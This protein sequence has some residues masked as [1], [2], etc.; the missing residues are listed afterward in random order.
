M[1]KKGFLLV[2][3]LV[4]FMAGCS[5][6]PFNTKAKLDYDLEGATTEYSNL[7]ADNTNEFI[8]SI[9]IKD[10]NAVGANLVEATVSINGENKTVKIIENKVSGNTITQV[11]INP[12]LDTNGNLIKAFTALED[13]NTI[14][15]VKMKFKDINENEI[16]LGEMYKSIKV[17]KSSSGT[18]SGGEVDN[19]PV[20][21]TNLSY[22]VSADGSKITL[23]WIDNGNSLENDILGYKVYREETSNGVYEEGKETALLAS[24]VAIVT[25]YSTQYIDSSVTAGKAYIY[26]VTAVDRAS[27]ESTYKSKPLYVAIYKPGNYKVTSLVGASVE[28]T[29]N[30]KLTWTK[31]VNSTESNTAT[32]KGYKI[33]RKDNSSGYILIKDINNADTAEFIDYD[34]N[35]VE[36]KEYTYKVVVYDEIGKEGE[37][38]ETTSIRVKDI[39]A[40]T[41]PSGIVLTLKPAYKL[42]IA[43]SKNNDLDLKDY[44]IEYT[45]NINSTTWSSIT[46]SGIT[47]TEISLNSSETEKT[48]YVRMKATDTSDNKSDYSNTE[49][50]IIDYSSYIPAPSNIV[51]SGGP[52]NVTLTW[53]K[54]TAV[55]GYDVI[56]YKIK[57]GTTPT[58]LTEIIET[59]SNNT[60]ITSATTPGGIKT[61][62]IWYFSIAAVEKGD[63]ENKVEGAYSRIEDVVVYDD[64]PFLRDVSTDLSPKGV[65]VKW[66]DV[67]DSETTGYVIY[68]AVTTGGTPTE[69]DFSYLEAKSKSDF[70]VQPDFNGGSYSWKVYQDESANEIGKT[71]WYKVALYNGVYDSTNPKTGKFSQSVAVEDKGAPKAIEYSTLNVSAMEPQHKMRIS[72]GG[73]VFDRED[74]AGFKVYISRT[75][76]GTYYYAGKTSNSY[77]DLNVNKDGDF[78]TIS[79][80]YPLEREDAKWKNIGITTGSGITSGAAIISNSEVSGIVTNVN[81]DDYLKIEEHYYKVTDKTAD[82]VSVKPNII[83]NISAE[84]EVYMYQGDT[85]PITETRTVSL[86]DPMGN[87]MFYIKVDAYNKAGRESSLTA[88]KWI[89][90]VPPAP[91]RLNVKVSQYTDDNSKQVAKIEWSNNIEATNFQVYKFVGQNSLSSSDL[92]IEGLPIT[93]VLL[94]ETSDYKYEDATFNDLTASTNVVY[95]VVPVD[96]Y[97][98][99]GSLYVLDSNYKVTSTIIT[100]AYGTVAR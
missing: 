52:K 41:A 46:I 78:D 65:M 82:H 88:Y 93:G 67:Y 63:G 12:F 95:A 42:N 22:D 58:N 74:L 27:Q 60:N 77:I 40:P 50:I 54:V 49:S 97:G 6:P 26:L 71:Y 31:P 86:K 55:A 44:T 25:T 34:K 83:G 68:R 20:P 94:G 9:P 48:I 98:N 16:V 38:A 14:K 32:V 28:G 7:S 30:I 36:N 96:S 37:A 11:K 5:L 3:I 56:G 2:A 33:Y 61:A 39:T 13:S 100:E 21:P 85:G 24:S 47:T 8:M 15:I 53:D 18:T 57:Y 91:K 4:L 81:K 75:G 64:L 51:L 73:Y 45:D 84:K 87:R 90:M 72:W 80:T 43:W 17:S 19:K 59:F 62:G 89:D 23:N 29:I 66:K 79:S 10:E 35:L 69:D 70:E 92:S 1:Q 76:E 99:K